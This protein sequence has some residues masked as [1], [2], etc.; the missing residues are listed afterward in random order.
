MYG[1]G[2]S[3]ACVPF[4]PC[5]DRFVPAGYR[6]DP[7]TLEQKLEKIAGLGD[8]S[9]V[10]LSFP[11]EF[12]DPISMAKILNRVDLKASNIEVDIFGS[13]KWKYGALSSRDDKIRQ[14]AISLGK[15]CMEAAA[16]LGC[17]QISLW[18]GQDGFDYR[19]ALKMGSLPRV[20]SFS[21]SLD[22]VA[23][24][25]DDIERFLAEI[26]AVNAKNRIIGKKQGFKT[27]YDHITLLTN[28]R[29]VEDHFPLIVEGLKS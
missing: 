27:D 4:Y 26:G 13:P 21:G 6:Q 1:K 23:G 28:P 22:T 20:Q 7:Y 11:A 19:G 16:E 12:E 9:G 5:G 17:E 14:E 25:P 10:E 29:A 3:V 18:P 8:V 15:R 2:L 24:N